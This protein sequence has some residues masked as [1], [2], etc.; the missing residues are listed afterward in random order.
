MQQVVQLGRRLVTTM[1]T[2]NNPAGTAVEVVRQQKK[3][4]RTVVRRELRNFSPEAKREEDEA[5]QKHILS[6]EW[7]QNS[8]RICA[9]VS[10]ASLREVDTSHIMADLLEKQRRTAGMKV[11]VPRIEDK[12]SHMRMLH[13]TNTDDDLI[14]NYMNILEPTLLDSVGNPREEVMQATEPLDLLLLPGL[15]FD[16]KGGRLGR[17]GGYYDLFLQNYLLLAKDKG[18]KS[19][20]LGELGFCIRLQCSTSVSLQKELLQYFMN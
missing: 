6:A 15:A 1:A 14:A 17:G 4:L 3:A 18:W 16:R 13:I 8:K 2:L 19:P 12:E 9:Y 11:Y 10:C 20:L 7:Y 5:I